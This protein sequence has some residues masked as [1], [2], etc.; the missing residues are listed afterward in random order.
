MA[1][2]S[3]LSSFNIYLVVLISAASFLLIPK[4]KYWDKESIFIILFSILYASVLII[5]DRVISWANTISYAICPILFYRMGVYI[6]DKTTKR[7]LVIILTMLVACLTFPLLMSTIDSIVKTGEFVNIYRTLGSEGFEDDTIGATYYGLYASLGLACVSMLFTRMQKALIY[8]I[9]ALCCVIA[10][11]LTTI[12]LVNRTGLIILVV[13]LLLAILYS[14]KGSILKKLLLLGVCS[15]VVVA[16]LY[17]VLPDLTTDEIFEAYLSREED[18][19]FDLASGGGRFKLSLN[20]MQKMFYNPFGMPEESYAHNMWLD[21][22][23]VA[24]F[25]PFVPFIVATFINYKQV[26]HILKGRDMEIAPYLLGL[27]V[28]LLLSCMVEPIIEAS[29]LYLYI[30]MMM[31]GVNSMVFTKMTHPN[32]YSV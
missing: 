29:A 23:R 12:H 7:G 5:D 16:V 17:W 11:L 2:L 28:A 26:W 18:A 6:A 4:Y 15:G 3:S 10:A 13:C 32:S 1:L 30:V 27:N 14:T 9:L 21:I 24:G 20:V 25:L 19:D 8:K 22:I 31:W